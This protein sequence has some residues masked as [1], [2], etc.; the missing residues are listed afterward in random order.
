M[1]LHELSLKVL[2]SE[3]NG[4]PEGSMVSFCCKSS[5]TSSLL[6]QDIC[7]ETDVWS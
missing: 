3:D 6:L 7:C 4:W 2:H 5:E 1:K